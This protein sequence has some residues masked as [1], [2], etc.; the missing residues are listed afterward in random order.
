MT[1]VFSEQ[2]REAVDR[3]DGGPVT[4][5]DPNFHATY[6]VFRSDGFDRFRSELQADNVVKA[7]LPHLADLAPED[8]EDASNYEVESK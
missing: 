6:V 1:A 3:A 8:W 7:M 5:Q 2:L 4:V